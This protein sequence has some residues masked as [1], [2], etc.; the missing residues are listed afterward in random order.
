MSYV[1]G[2]F[3]HTVVYIFSASM[4][5]SPRTPTGVGPFSTLRHEIKHRFS[6]KLLISVPC[7]Y[8]NRIMFTGYK[9]KECGYVKSYHFLTNKQKFSEKNGKL[10]F[11]NLNSKFLI[12][13]DIRNLLFHI[14]PFISSLL[15]IFM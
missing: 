11:A 13:A 15:A 7:D 5:Q 4:S 9:C 14:L 8:C 2:Y 6:A 10:M 1:Q 3:M 12:R